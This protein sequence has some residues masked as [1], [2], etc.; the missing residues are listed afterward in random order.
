MRGSGIEVALDG[1]PLSMAL[2]IGP[3][4]LPLELPLPPL[5]PPLDPALYVNRRG[6]TPSPPVSAGAPPSPATAP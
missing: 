3:P 4:S 1:L 2:G 5:D 6:G